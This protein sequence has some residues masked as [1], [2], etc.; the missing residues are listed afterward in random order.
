MM[1]YI[2]CLFYAQSACRI[3][4][5]YNIDIVIIIVIIIIIILLFIFDVIIMTLLI[6]HLDTKN[7]FVVYVPIDVDYM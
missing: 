6:K 1:N 3:F 4:K 2:T 7:V 5:Y